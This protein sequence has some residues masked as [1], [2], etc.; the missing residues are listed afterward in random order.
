MPL[1]AEFLVVGLVRGSYAL[2]DGITPKGYLIVVGEGR[3]VR[4]K[5][6][7]GEEGGGAAR[8]PIPPSPTPSL[9][10]P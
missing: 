5:C 4:P 6:L 3:V 10:W 8:A 9:K 7:H 1:D 2:G